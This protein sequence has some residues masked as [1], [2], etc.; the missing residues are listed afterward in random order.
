MSKFSEH[1]QPCK[2]DC[3]PC[4]KQAGYREGIRKAASHLH[5]EIEEAQLAHESSVFLES[6]LRRILGDL[7]SE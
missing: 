2:P 3:I 4:A 6:L 5:K 7:D 1:P